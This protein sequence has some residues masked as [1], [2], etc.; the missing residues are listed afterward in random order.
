MPAGPIRQPGRWTK[1]SVSVAAVSVDS[2]SPA[3]IQERLARPDQ[4]HGMSAGSFG[5]IR[6]STALTVTEV[7]N[8]GFSTGDSEK[9]PSPVRKWKEPKLPGIWFFRT[10]HPGY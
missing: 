7:R 1:K 4:T 10:K 5:H 6:R 8:L 9:S 3:A 2:S